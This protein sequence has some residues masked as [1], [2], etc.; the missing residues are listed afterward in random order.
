MNTETPFPI[1][2]GTL[3]KVI[4]ETGYE[5]KGSNTIACDRDSTFKFVEQPACQETGKFIRYCV[6]ILYT[7]YMI[8]IIMYNVYNI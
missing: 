3:V 1:V 7:L 4:C 8:I 6:Y 5:L 2:F